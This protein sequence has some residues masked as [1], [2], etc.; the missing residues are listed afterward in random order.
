MQDRINADAEKYGKR[1]YY[2]DRSPLS[3]AP[4]HYGKLGYIVGAMA[5]NERAQ[6][7][8]DDIK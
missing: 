6:R 8:A 5:E 4:Q 7:L 1:P 2:K 3:S